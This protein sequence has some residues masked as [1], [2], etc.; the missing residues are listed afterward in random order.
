MR[1]L[2]RLGRF[3]KARLFVCGQVHVKARV[4]MTASPANNTPLDH[5]F[6]ELIKE[7]LQ[8]RRELAQ[9]REQ[10]AATAEILTVISS[11]PTNVQSVFDVIASSEGQTAHLSRATARVQTRPRRW[12]PALAGRST[13]AA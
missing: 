11:S 9:A 7:L 3:A 5:K 6:E 1:G 12:S 10:Q 13:K 2:R 4:V 8:A